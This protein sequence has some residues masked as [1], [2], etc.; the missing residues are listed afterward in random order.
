MNGWSMKLSY[1]LTELHNEII[2]MVDSETVYT[3]K[4]LKKKLKD[5]YKDHIFFAE[6]NGKSDVVC[7]KDT[8][9]LIINNAWYEAREKDAEDSE[10]IIKTAA[11]LILADIRTTKIDKEYYPTE[12]E[13]A[14][15]NFCEN[16]QPTALRQFL[17]IIVKDRLK[18]A[19]L[20]Q[21]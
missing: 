18:R 20:G 15:I 19:S 13:I 14:D 17:E 10:R 1:T 2:G 12:E 5:K 7:L 9:S 4:W 16:A 8:A 6:L 21:C 3:T 11:K